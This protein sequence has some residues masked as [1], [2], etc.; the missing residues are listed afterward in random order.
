M[1]PDFATRDIYLSLEQNSNEEKVCVQLVS[2][3]VILQ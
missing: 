2:K 3:K 1:W